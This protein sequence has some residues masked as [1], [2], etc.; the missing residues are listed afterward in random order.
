MLAQSFVLNAPYRETVITAADVADAL[1]LVLDLP[2]SLELSHYGPDDGPLFRE[3]QRIANPNP[4]DADDDIPPTGSVDPRDRDFAELKERSGSVDGS[5]AQLFQQDSETVDQYGT[6]Y[7]VIAPKETALFIPGPWS[8]RRNAITPRHVINSDFQ[9]RDR[10]KFRKAC[11]KDPAAFAAAIP[12]DIHERVTIRDRRAEALALLDAISEPLDRCIAVGDIDPRGDVRP[13]APRPIWA[14]RSI[15]DWFNAPG[16]EQITLEGYQPPKA[17][18]RS[19][20]LPAVEIFP[21][22]DGSI[23]IALR[24]TE[25]TRQKA[26]RSRRVH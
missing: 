24:K 13:V 15:A 5:C 11:R 4:E 20:P 25:F 10:A 7:K 6:G 12:N 3:D 19:R 21:G 16:D 23:G 14:G 22:P 8:F 1:R 9:Y 26:G 17:R 2:A 18:L